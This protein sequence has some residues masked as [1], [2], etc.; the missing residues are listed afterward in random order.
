MARN[1]NTIFFDTE[2]T[3]LDKKNKPHTHP[4]QP[5]PVQIGFKVDAPGMREIGVGNFLIQTNTI[6]GLEPKKVEPGAF[7]STGISNEIA[8]SFGVHLIS[9]MEI[10]LDYM[11]ICDIVVAHNISYDRVVIRRAMQIYCDATGQAYRD[12]FEGKILLCTMFGA[13]NLV[14]ALPKRNGEWKWPRLE[15]CMQ[16]FFGEKLEGAHDAL[17]DVRACARVYYH[18]QQIGAFHDG[19]T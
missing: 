1:M 17:V 16:H 4:D 10:F 9:A 14:K 5:F 3:G 7:K 19:A 11:D 2:T 8:D 18:L 13:Q 12:P 15:E 6:D